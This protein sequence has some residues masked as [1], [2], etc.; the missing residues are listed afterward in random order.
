MLFHDDSRES[1][2]GFY[3]LSLLP[4]LSLT[5]NYIMHFRCIHFITGHGMTYEDYVGRLWVKK[6]VKVCAH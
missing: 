4:P 5:V 6:I 2:K 1:S 3:F